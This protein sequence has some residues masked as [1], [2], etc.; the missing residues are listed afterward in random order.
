MNAANEPAFPS[1]EGPFNPDTGRTGWGPSFGLSKRELFAGLVM[2]GLA[3]SEANGGMYSAPYNAMAVR[4]VEMADALV[5]ALNTR[6]E[7]GAAA[8]APVELPF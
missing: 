2:Q 7:S 5:L 1:P 4:A 6:T 8:D 3:A